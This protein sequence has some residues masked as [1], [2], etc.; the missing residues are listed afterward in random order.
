[1]QIVAGLKLPLDR[2]D[3]TVQKQLAGY[4]NIFYFPHGSPVLIKSHVPTEAE[5]EEFLEDR[6]N[7]RKLPVIPMGD[8]CTCG[9][10]VWVFAEMLGMVFEYCTRCRRALR[11]SIVKKVNVESLKDFDLEDIFGD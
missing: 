9:T 10:S 6:L 11:P 3:Y 7:I 8:C 4:F 5:C 1:M 2:E